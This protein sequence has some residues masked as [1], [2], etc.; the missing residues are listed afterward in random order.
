MI[1]EQTIASADIRDERWRCRQNGEFS[2]V[3]P[4]SYNRGTSGASKALPSMNPADFALLRAEWQPRL[5]N[6]PNRAAL[7]A[8]T[9]E[10][11]GPTLQIR[12]HGNHGFGAVA[13]AMRAYA[14]WNGFTL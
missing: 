11:S 6:E 9:G 1:S 10:T 13:S 3:R 8:W 12:V 7:A 4:T 5:F 2:H 14:G